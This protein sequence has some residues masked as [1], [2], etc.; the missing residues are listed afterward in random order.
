MSFFDFDLNYN[1]PGKIHSMRHLKDEV[2]SVKN[3]GECGL[4]FEG[5][6]VGVGVKEGEEQENFI[7]K[8]GDHII[9][10]SHNH[11]TQTSEWD[12]GF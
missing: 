5:L 1:P 12:P 8:E 10:Y 9:C 7:P 6:G 11:V 4:A 2:E 3:G